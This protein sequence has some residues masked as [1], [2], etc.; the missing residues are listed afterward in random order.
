MIR[1][2][3]KYCGGCDPKYDR[4]SLVNK[5]ET[6]FSGRVEFFPFKGQDVD[7]VLVVN[8]CRRACAE[9]SRYSELK[10]WTISGV[11]EV[12]MLIRKK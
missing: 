12:E 3:V 11:S 2:G 6:Q 10:T 8:G 4:L 9:I 1:I 7:F 5:L